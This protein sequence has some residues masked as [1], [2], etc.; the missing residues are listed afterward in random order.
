M[1][2]TAERGP[3]RHHR[4]QKVLWFL[5]TNMYK[6]AN[7]GTRIKSRD[8]IDKVGKEANVMYWSQKTVMVFLSF[9][10]L[11]TILELKISP[12]RSIWA[13]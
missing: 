9:L 11:A 5:K 8:Y 4:Q 6:Y 12:F 10:N 7:Q 2:T 1:D 3:E 13:N